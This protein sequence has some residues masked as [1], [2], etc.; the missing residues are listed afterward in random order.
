M[1]VLCKK[2]SLIFMISGSTEPTLGNGML[3]NNRRRSD[4]L[5]QRTL[6]LIDLDNL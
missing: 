1:V 6:R 5:N 4:F 2:I 3:I